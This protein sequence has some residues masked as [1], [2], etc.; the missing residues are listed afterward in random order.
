[1][2]EE[3]VCICP[4][5]GAWY[6][7]NK[8][9]SGPECPDCKCFLICTNISSEEF[10]SLSDE[11]RNS[12]MKKCFPSN[13]NA[14]RRKIN[15]SSFWIVT[16]EIISAIIIAA[17]IIFGIFVLTSAKYIGVGIIGFVIVVAIGIMAVSSLM[18]FIGIA[19]DVKA[20]RGKL[21]S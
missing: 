13:S 20:I 7:V 8:K 12:I 19:K 16:M 21:K 17:S 14:D 2:N 10:D 6:Y 3:R 5:C 15:D 4:K 18:V 11:E 9:N 1:M